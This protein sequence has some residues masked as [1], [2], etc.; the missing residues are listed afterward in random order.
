MKRKEPLPN[1]GAAAVGIIVLVG[2]IAFGIA[3]AFYYDPPL[4]PYTPKKCEPTEIKIQN[5]DGWWCVS[6]RKL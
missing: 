6:A 4:V 5:T 1:E 2:I 3:A